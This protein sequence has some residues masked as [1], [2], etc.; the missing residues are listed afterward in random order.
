MRASLILLVAAAVLFVA[1]CISPPNRS[2]GGGETIATWKINADEGLAVPHCPRCDTVV[3]RKFL[4]CQG[5]GIDCRIVQ[6]TIDC[7]DCTATGECGHCNVK[8]TCIPCDGSGRCVICDGEGEYGGA[9]C[10]EC[11]GARYCHDC[12][13]CEDTHVCAN[14]G[15]DGEIELR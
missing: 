8:G 10:P 1:G 7:P 13:Y 11:E 2:A 12:E 15:G 5:C 3:N 14:C 9:E 6:K 4:A